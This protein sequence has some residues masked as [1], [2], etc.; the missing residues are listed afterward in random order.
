MLKI[1]SEVQGE[2]TVMTYLYD[3]DIFGGACKAG[4]SCMKLLLDW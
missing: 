4:S 3:N 1:F 2:K